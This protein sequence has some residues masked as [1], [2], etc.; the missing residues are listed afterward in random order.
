MP[1]MQQPWTLNPLGPGLNLHTCNDPG[2][3]LNPQQELLHAL[4]NLTFM[5][6]FRERPGF[7]PWQ[8]LRPKDMKR[9]FPGGLVVKGSSD[10]TAVV[11]IIAVVRV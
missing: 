6:T 4:F 5:Q 9:E 7:S 1:Q 11:Q 3:T 2:R 10:V 8:K